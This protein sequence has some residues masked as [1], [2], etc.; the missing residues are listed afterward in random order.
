VLARTTHLD[1]L[2]WRLKEPR[3]APIVQAVLTGDLSIPYDHDDFRYV[4]DLGLLVRHRDGARAANR[5]YQEVLAR[6]V[7]YNL[8]ENLPT[9]RWRWSTSEGRLDFPA[10]VEAFRAW[11][12]E[13]A[14]ALVEDIPL[15]PEAIPH[16]ALMAFLQRV[17]NGGGAVT[18]E[19]AAGRGALDLLVQYGQDR[20]AVE[21]KRV[22]ARDGLERIRSAGL[23][24]LGDYLA[25]VGLSE[26]WL[27]VFDQRPGRSW[28]ERTFREDV[29]YEGR[30][31]RIVG[32]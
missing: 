15:Y 25:T 24:Q 27:F 28:E 3:V 18:G 7:T 5:V 32:G 16:L 22:R 23:A 26:G 19:Y 29:V 6:Q 10:L 17:V 2:A 14:D 11:W 4:V 8:Q 20:F 9:P 12:R 30:T 1:S 13:N 21:I 31:I